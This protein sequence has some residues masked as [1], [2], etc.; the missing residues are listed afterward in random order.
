MVREAG[1]GVEKNHKSL[2]AC[3]LLLWLRHGFGENFK[4]R[5]LRDRVSF[6]LG[7]KPGRMEYFVELKKKVLL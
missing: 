4:K 6:V 7:E 5:K 2:G 1:V 3:F